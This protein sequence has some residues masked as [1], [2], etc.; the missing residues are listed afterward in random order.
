MPPL[1][2]SWSSS[3]ESV[4]PVTQLEDDDCGAENSNGC[5]RPPT[6]SR[7]CGG[8]AEA[9]CPRVLL[10]A[11]RFGLLLPGLLFFRKTRHTTHSPAGSAT[12]PCSS[13]ANVK[14][15]IRQSIAIE[16]AKRIKL[17]R[18]EARFSYLHDLKHYCIVSYSI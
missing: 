18:T 3:D 11:S 9:R 5:C 4:T 16:V 10:L 6:S 2:T 15:H 8:A 13:G 14:L 7:C 17:L 1:L 12:Q